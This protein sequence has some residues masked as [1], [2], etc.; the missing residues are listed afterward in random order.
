MLGQTTLLSYAIWLELSKPTRAKLAQLFGFTPHGTP[1][2][3]IGAQ[4]A[5]IIADEYSLQDLS[6]ITLEKMQQ[7]LNSD[8]T[9]FYELFNKIVENLDDL[10]NPKVA[11][12]KEINGELIIK[13]VKVEESKI[14]FT[15]EEP[16]VQKQPFCTLCN[17]LGVRHKNGCP[18]KTF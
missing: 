11:S 8:S 7:L 2:V 10:L 5:V 9:N 1:S 12:V 17:S 3:S 13:E 4:G 14:T 16:P 15:S 6:V 18:N